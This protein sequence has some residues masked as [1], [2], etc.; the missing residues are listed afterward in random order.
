M[1]LYNL[2]A[3]IGL[4]IIFLTIFKLMKET[5][6]KKANINLSPRTTRLS[7]KTTNE[8][9]VYYRDYST[10]SMVY[11]GKIVERRRKE[12]GNNHQDLLKKARKDYSPRVKDPNSIF[13]LSQTQSNP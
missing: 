8:F 2:I 1:E 6:P 12:R 4:S 11:I 9:D 7:K 5:K 3:I 13:L 10:K